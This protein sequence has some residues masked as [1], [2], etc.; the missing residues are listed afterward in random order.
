MP[1]VTM[2]W[3]HPGKIINIFMVIVRENGALTVMAHCTHKV[4]NIGARKKINAWNLNWMN[5]T[6]PPHRVAVHDRE[7]LR[8]TNA[9]LLFHIMKSNNTE[10]K[11]RVCELY[12]CTRAILTRTFYS[13]IGVK[14]GSVTLCN[15]N[16]LQCYF[17]QCEN[18]IDHLGR[19]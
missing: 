4:R 9:N 7:C 5:S 13:C 1:S 6:A 11:I 12:D 16:I 2:K 17:L 15:S 19:C 18:N 10:K 8:A 3:I 14:T